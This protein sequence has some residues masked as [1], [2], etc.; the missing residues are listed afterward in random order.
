MVTSTIFNMELCEW[1]FR[2]APVMRTAGARAMNGI[3]SQQKP[4]PHQ[5]PCP[6]LLLHFE[7]RLHGSIALGK[8]RITTDRSPHGI[9]YILL[10]RSTSGLLNKRKK[11]KN[12]NKNI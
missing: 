1:R 12:E 9:I 8:N 5:P 6:L 2:C 11:E 7:Y 10:C 4:L 3:S